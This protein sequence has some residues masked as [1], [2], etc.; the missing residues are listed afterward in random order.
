MISAMRAPCLVTLGVLLCAASPGAAQTSDTAFMFVPSAGCVIPD[1]ELTRVPVYVWADLPDSASPAF[2]SLAENLM[3]DIVE[4]VPAV[5]GVSPDSLPRGEPHV[6]WLDL[7]NPLEVTGYR[8]G[9]IAW[10]SD[11]IWNHGAADLLGRALGAAVAD[12][13]FFP[14]DSSLRGD[15]VRFSYAFVTPRVDLSG[16]VQPLQV[17]HAAVPAF[18][19]AE[20]R[21]QEVRPDSGNPPP[22]YPDDAR[23]SNFRASLVVQFV[24]DTAGRAEMAT[25]HDIWPKDKPRLSPDLQKIYDEFLQSVLRDLPSMHFYPATLGRSCRMRQIVRMPFVFNLTR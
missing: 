4:R 11:G 18:S 20:P 15:S 24:V 23:R 9:R 14:W 13:T 25:A 2:R 6:S 7:R 5:L 16:Q 8:N 21:F 1:S 3:Q 22:H 10:R 19:I 17:E 12:S